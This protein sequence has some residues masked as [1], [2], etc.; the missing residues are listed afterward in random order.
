MLQESVQTDV[1]V[2]LVVLHDVDECF[3]QQGRVYTLVVGVEDLAVESS[4][5][6][7]DSSKPSLASVLT[8]TA[9]VTGLL[10]TA[11]KRVPSS[12]MTSD[13]S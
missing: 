7:D 13:C 3:K 1:F 6:P 9:L 2:C 5:P 8:R 12:V 4:P 11:E 10:R